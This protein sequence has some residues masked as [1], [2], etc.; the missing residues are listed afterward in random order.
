MQVD[1]SKFLY[2]ENVMGDLDYYEEAEDIFVY[3]DS[4]EWY[5]IY[6]IDASEADA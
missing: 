6:N 2:N 4:G 3:D 1:M 5:N